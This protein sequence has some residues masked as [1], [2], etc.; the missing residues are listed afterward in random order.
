MMKKREFP[1]GCLSFSVKV[2][3]IGKRKVEVNFPAGEGKGES[4]YY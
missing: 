3:T 1:A 4:N 2:I